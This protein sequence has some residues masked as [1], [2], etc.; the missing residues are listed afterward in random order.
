MIFFFLGILFFKKIQHIKILSYKTYKS[1]IP[2]R[3]F[4]QDYLQDAYK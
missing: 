4:K 1:R 3:C 2:K